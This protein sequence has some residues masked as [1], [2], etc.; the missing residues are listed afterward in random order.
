MEMSPNKNFTAYLPTRNTWLIKGFEHILKGWKLFIQDVPDAK[1]YITYYGSDA[2]FT[3][4]MVEYLGIKDNVEFIRLVPKERFAE[5]INASDVII[6]QVHLGAIG[7]VTVQAMACEK[8]V[9]VNA[10]QKWYREQYGETVPIVNARDA[11][12]VYQA[13]LDVYYK[14]YNGLG[15][16]ARRYVKRNHSY[17]VV[18]K[19][20]KERYEDILC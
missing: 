3:A 10:N 9:I 20:V 5:M 18:A 1:L 13:L 11:N 19:K 17:E 2:K 7:G 12:G 16:D 15:K 4:R 8:K 14:K 6:D